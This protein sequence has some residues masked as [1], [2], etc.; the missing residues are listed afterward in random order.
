MN[1]PEFIDYVFKGIVL[2]GGVYLIYFL[3]SIYET[4]IQVLEVTQVDK[5][6]DKMN[7]FK[8]LNEMERQ[9]EISS[10]KQEMEKLSEQNLSKDQIIE[11]QKRLI[12]DFKNKMDDYALKLWEKLLDDSLRVFSPK[13]VLEVDSWE[14][15]LPD[16]ETSAKYTKTWTIKF[17]GKE[18]I[19]IGKKRQKKEE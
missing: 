4:K 18:I 13:Y 12:D 6:V 14:D 17:N 1:W 9:Y 7:K 10:L 3:R 16:N 8:E 15:I 2:A 5:F 19:R 11:S